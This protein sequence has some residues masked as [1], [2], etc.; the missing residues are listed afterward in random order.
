MTE[1]HCTRQ[2]KLATKRKFGH[3]CQAKTWVWAVRTEFSL[4]AFQT[5]KDANL[6]LFFFFVRTNKTPITQ[7]DL[8]FQSAIK[9]NHHAYSNI[10]E[11]SPPTTE[12]FQIKKTLIFFHISA[13]N[14]DCGYSFE[15]PRRGG[16]NEFP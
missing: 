16:S 15:P 14:I 13:Q 4:G 9:W 11:I 7:T 12:T 3:V 1:K 10:K 2:I 8:G 6:F 5:A